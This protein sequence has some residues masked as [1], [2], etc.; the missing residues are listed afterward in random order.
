MGSLDRVRNFARSVGSGHPAGNRGWTICCEKRDSARERGRDG[1]FDTDTAVTGQLQPGMTKVDPGD[2]AQ[3][4]HL[5]TFDPAKLYSGVT[6]QIDLEPGAAVGRSHI[7]SI[8]EIA[9]D[10][11]R[12]QRHAKLGN[13]AQDRSNETITVRPRP[14]P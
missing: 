8:P 14:N 12:R 4:I 9:P 13:G 1:R 7:K 11:V 5:D 6:V 3:K 10:G 2:K